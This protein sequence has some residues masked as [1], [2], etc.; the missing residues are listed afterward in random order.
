MSVQNRR[1][2]HDKARKGQREA[3][4]LQAPLPLH[5]KDMAP[6]DM[7]ASS[8]NLSDHRHPGALHAVHKALRHIIL[9][10][11][12]DSKQVSHDVGARVLYDGLVLSEQ[13]QNLP[14][15]D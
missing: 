1:C 12:V 4:T 3:K 15:E 6:E 9:A 2:Q 14:R 13:S 8:D 11:H 5:D 10:E 7:E